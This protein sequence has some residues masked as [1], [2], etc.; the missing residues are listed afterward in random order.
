MRR[1]EVIFFALLAAFFFG[2][3]PIL[4]KTGLKETDPLTGLFIRSAVVFSI[5]LLAVIALGKTGD[6]QNIDRT[7]IMYLG[8]GGISAALVGHLLYYYALKGGEASEVV[9]VASIYPLV[10]LVLA[11]VFLGE[12][13]T[14]QKLA[15]AILI[16]VGVILIK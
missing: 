7:T 16:V 10:A 4:E 11:V 5:L 15:G 14:L 9:P 6:I 2:L 13:A 12:K 3:S 8:A 1:M